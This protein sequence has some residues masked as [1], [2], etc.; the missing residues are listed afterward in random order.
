MALP[1][2]YTEPTFAQYL[3]AQLSRVA[4]ELGWSDGSGVDAGSYSEV[5]NDTLLACGIDDIGQM[6]TRDELRKL[7]VVGRYYAWRAAVESLVT[8]H[9]L[10]ADGASLSRSAVFN[11]ARQMLNRAEEEAAVYGIGPA[12]EGAQVTITTVTRTDPYA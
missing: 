4:A 6:T 5:I 8:E 2:S 1:S 11:Q 7:R 10:A 9:D 12:A 3:H